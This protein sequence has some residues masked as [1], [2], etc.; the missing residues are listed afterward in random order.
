VVAASKE[1]GPKMMNNKGKINR[2]PAAHTKNS[3]LPPVLCFSTSRNQIFVFLLLFFDIFS[4]LGAPENE[5]H[6]M[7]AQT[8]ERCD[9]YKFRSIWEN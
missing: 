1:Q 2:Y 3:K 5:Q 6:Q 7:S 4:Q 8:N 9:W